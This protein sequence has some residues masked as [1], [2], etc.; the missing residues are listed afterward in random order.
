MIVVRHVGP[1]Q[2]VA[3]AV[4][5]VVGL[6][7]VLVVGQIAV[8]VGVRSGA[9]AAVAVVTADAAE[10]VGIAETEAEVTGEQK[11]RRESD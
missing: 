7:N 11:C 6:R 9:G 5:S 3:L 4:A 2:D 1:R 8:R 10:I